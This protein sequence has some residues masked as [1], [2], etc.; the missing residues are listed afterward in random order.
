MMAVHG[1]GDLAQT[2]AF[3]PHFRG[4]ELADYAVF[5]V[6]TDFLYDLYQ[7]RYEKGGGMQRVHGYMVFLICEYPL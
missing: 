4:K 2:R 3:R 6:V 7:R 1:F 5:T